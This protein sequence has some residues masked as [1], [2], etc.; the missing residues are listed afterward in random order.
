MYD[1]DPSEDI[2]ND[3]EIQDGNQTEENLKNLETA[4]KSEGAEAEAKLKEARA[5][6]QAQL[7][8]L[9]KKAKE[10]KDKQ[11]K[12]ISDLVKERSGKTVTPEQVDNGVDNFSTEKNTGDKTQDA[13]NDTIRNR[14]NPLLNNTDLK[15]DAK[16]TSKSEFVKKYGPKFLKGLKYGYEGLK[17]GLGFGIIGGIIAG[18]VY[19]LFQIG[20]KSLKEIAQGSTGCYQEINDPNLG[21][22]YYVGPCSCGFNLESTGTCPVVDIPNIKPKTIPFC[23]SSN[24]SNFLQPC[25]YTTQACKSIKSSG[26]CDSS[27]Q[28]DSCKKNP[29]A[30]QCK[31]LDDK[32]KRVTGTFAICGNPSNILTKMMVLSDNADSWV[33]QPTPPITI[34]ITILGIIGIIITVLWYIIFLIRQERKM[35]KK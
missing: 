25:D 34:I 10:Y 24:F 3:A 14:L 9:N 31:W 35:G 29:N 5:Q 21:Y 17:Y 6:A 30:I 19:E 12:Y 15:N 18:A 16:N 7:N 11:N 20:K 13:I 8:K 27:C 22:I 32:D 23:S 2:K 4:A 28:N 33:P 1:Y 26:T